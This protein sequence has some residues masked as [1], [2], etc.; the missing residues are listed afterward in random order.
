M[1]GDIPTGWTCPYPDTS[2]TYIEGPDGVVVDLDEEVM[3]IEWS[4]SCDDHY[5]TAT[6]RVGVPT[7]LLQALLA[8]LGA[9]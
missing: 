8:R 6:R 5:G 7:A 3:V 9:T 4:E 2:P 1:S